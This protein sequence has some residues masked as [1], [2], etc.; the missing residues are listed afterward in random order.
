MRQC[1]DWHN[2]S[3]KIALGVEVEP[4]MLSHCITSNIDFYF[5]HT[6]LNTSWYLY[7]PY[8]GWM[9]K[10]RIFVIFIGIQQIGVCRH[11]YGKGRVSM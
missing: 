1:T 8:V 5:I 10:N 6:C 3:I 9:E 11:R 2:L 4:G 7:P